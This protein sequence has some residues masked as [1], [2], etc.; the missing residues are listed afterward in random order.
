[1]LFKQCDALNPNPFSHAGQPSDAAV[2][3]DLEIKVRHHPASD[4]FYFVREC[5]SQRLKFN[6]KDRD[7]TDKRQRVSKKLHTRISRTN[8]IQIR[9][10]N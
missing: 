7:R 4:G 2:V 10:L 9:S 3:K 1:M 6:V 8:K 5:L